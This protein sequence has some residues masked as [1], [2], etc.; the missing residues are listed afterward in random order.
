M[1]RILTVLLIAAL[2]MGCTKNKKKDK[3]VFIPPTPANPNVLLSLT[4]T[5]STDPVNTVTDDTGALPPPL[6]QI[7]SSTGTAGVS[8]TPTTEPGSAVSFIRY[9]LDGAS[10]IEGNILFADMPNFLTLSVADAD[11]D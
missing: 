5:D 8:V 4:V 10:V 7:L 11:A 9:K 2:C 1:R 3:F 6:L